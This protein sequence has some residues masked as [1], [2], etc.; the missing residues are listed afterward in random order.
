VTEAALRF[1]HGA[2]S[3]DRGGIKPRSA[4]PAAL[5]CGRT[6][7]LARLHATATRPSTV[8]AGGQQWC[9]CTG[10]LTGTRGLGR[11]RVLGAGNGSHQHGKTDRQSERRAFHFDS[12]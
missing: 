9:H 2:R 12:C 3:L 1:E 5:R 7:R 4:S 10:S 11:G 8:T 6:K